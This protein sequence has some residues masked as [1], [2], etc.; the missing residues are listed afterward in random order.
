MNEVREPIAVSTTEAARM[1]G[2]SRPTIY[3]LLEKE[4]FP[5]FKLGA[6]TL[7]SVEGL[8]KWVERQT[9]EHMRSAG[10]N[11]V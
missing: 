5:A 8:K 2:V 7:I 4:N 9:D 3:K 1:L 6:R 11:T 10:S